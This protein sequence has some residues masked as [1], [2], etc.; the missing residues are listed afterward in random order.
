VVFFI[1]DIEL[2]TSMPDNVLTKGLSNYIK[3]FATPLLTPAQV[4]E[5]ERRLKALQAGTTVS[6]SERLESLEHDMSHS[7]CVPNVVVRL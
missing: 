2:K 4:V 7:H 1:G 3:R 5:I 6:R